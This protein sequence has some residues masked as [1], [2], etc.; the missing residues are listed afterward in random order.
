[1]LTL[2]PVQMQKCSTQGQHCTA[3]EKMLLSTIY[4]N[5]VEMRRTHRRGSTAQEEFRLITGFHYSTAFRHKNPKG[6]SGEGGEEAPPGPPHDDEDD[7]ED[8]DAVVSRNARIER[9]AQRSVKPTGGMG[10]PRKR[11]RSPYDVEKSYEHFYEWVLD[12]VQAAKKRGYLTVQ[13]LREDLRLEHD[14]VFS[15]RVLRRTLRRLGFEYRKRIGAWETRRAQPGVQAKLRE[16]LEFVVTNSSRGTDAGGKAHYSWNAPFAFFD[17]TYLYT[18]AFRDKSWC[19]RGDYTKD[20]GQ[21]G[22]DRRASVLHA[23]FSQHDPQPPTGNTLVHWLDSWTGKTREFKGQCTSEHILKYVERYLVQH[24]GEGGTLILDN[25]STHKEFLQRLDHCSTDEIHAFI[26]ERETPEGQKSFD[27][28]EKSLQHLPG[29]GR[30]YRHACQCPKVGGTCKSR[31]QQAKR[32]CNV[33][34]VLA[35]LG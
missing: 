14:L 7:A 16:F 21:L 17:E 22:A 26:I 5:I 32:R 29:S 6:H 4:D 30:K 15:K 9:L 1:V 3:D 33:P 20:R 34:S 35:F 10:P 12:K 31:K 25:C 2:G 13:R 19:L 28:F 27:A 11:G 23:L 18:R 24:I 8:D